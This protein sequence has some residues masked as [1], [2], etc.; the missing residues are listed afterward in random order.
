MKQDGSRAALGESKAAGGGV[1]LTHVNQF[2]S[3]RTEIFDAAPDELPGLLVVNQFR[4]D[5][6]MGRRELAVDQRVIRH[7]VRMNVLI[8]RTLDLY[9]LVAR[10]LA[11]AD[12][13]RELQLALESGGGWLEATVDRLEHHSG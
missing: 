5:D 6:N 4:N 8:L 9:T 10:R 1:T 12:D 2:N 3:H 7:A 13:S 11:G